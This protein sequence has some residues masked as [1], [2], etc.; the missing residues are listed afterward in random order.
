M[1]IWDS[2]EKIYD[3]LWVQKVSLEPTRRAVRA[4]I[5]RLAGEEASLIDIGCGT[6][7][8]LD[9]IRRDHPQFEYTGVEPSRL[10]QV[11]KER[12][13]FVREVSIAKLRGD[14]D[15][16]FVLCT[17]SFP[18]YS[19]KE[20]AIKKLADLTKSGGYLLIAHATSDT[21]YDKVMLQG[22]KLTTSKAN[23]PSEAEML[24]YLAPYFTEVEVV[25]VN[26]WYIPTIKLYIAKKR[27]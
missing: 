6:G 21:R 25:G 14:E 3:K 12:G 10:G 20:K 7:Q 17:H 16:D 4:Q 22:V 8:L 18:Y 2:Y 5:K 24:K 9:E 27:G 15:Y 1:G 11:A 19:N 26:K 23:Y 13:L